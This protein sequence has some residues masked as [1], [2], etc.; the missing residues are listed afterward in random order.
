[1][2]SAGDCVKAAHRVTASNVSDRELKVLKPVAT[3][4]SKIEIGVTLNVSEKTINRRERHDREALRD[5]R[6]AACSEGEGELSHLALRTGRW[7]W[8]PSPGFGRL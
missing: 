3:G 1:M 2:D 5:R 6:T 4:K 8:N 7:E